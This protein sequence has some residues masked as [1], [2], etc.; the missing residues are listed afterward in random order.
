MKRQVDRDG[1]D[2]E[3]EQDDAIV[4]GKTVERGTIN[5]RKERGNAE[6]ETNIRRGIR[7]IRRG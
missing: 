2:F 3:S 5:E 6:M 4:C 7:Q 1:L